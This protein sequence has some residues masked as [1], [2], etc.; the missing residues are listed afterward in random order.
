M[1]LFVC[2]LSEPIPIVYMHGINGNA[3]DSMHVNFVSEVAK[4]TGAYVLNCEVGTGSDSC[5]L[6]TI[7][8]QVEELRRCINDD[9]TVMNAPGFIGLGHSQGGYLMRALLQEHGHEELNMRRL[10]TLHAPL[11]GFYCGMKSDCNDVDL[12]DWLM[13]LGELAYTDTVQGLIGP[14]NYWRDP[15]NLLLYKR[16]ALS[17]P[18]LDNLRN[19]SEARKTN[20]LSVDKHIVFGS[21]VDNV[22]RPPVSTVFGVW[23]DGDDDAVIDFRQRDIYINDTFGLRT[24]DEQGRL[25]VIDDKLT[26]TGLFYDVEFIKNQICQ[27][28]VI[29]ELDV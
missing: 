13:E 3:N 15:Y 8:E 9:A 14:A 19:Y 21:S 18:E 27:Y 5:L 26:H 1:I 10:V 28:L 20:Y 16:K 11:G 24:M 6:M 12:P 4:N 17:L 7:E 25:V 2:L 22:I 29:D 23:A